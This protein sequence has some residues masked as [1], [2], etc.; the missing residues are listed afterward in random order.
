MRCRTKS[1][2]LPGGHLLPGVVLACAAPVAGALPSAGPVG[3]FAIGLLAI[4]CWLFSRQLRLVRRCER[5]R[6]KLVAE[7]ALRASAERALLERH[8]ALVAR[9]ASVQAAR[10]AERRRIG[11]DIHDDL[12]QH[13]LTLHLDIGALHANPQLPAWLQP[14][15]AMIERHLCLTVRSLRGVIDGLRPAALE[16]GLPQAVR[17]QL[18]EFARLSGVRC[19]LD[20]SG[21][22]GSAVPAVE[23]AMFRILQ[24]ALSNVLRH[25]AAS[26]VHVTLAR[27]PE[28]A[29]LT[30][31][32]NGIGLPP[33]RER[34]GQGLAGIADRVAAAGGRLRLDSQPGEG[35]SLCATV[36]VAP[37]D[38]AEADPAAVCG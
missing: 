10:L 26:E 12:G 28:G 16:H 2:Y 31:R 34:R 27:A 11:R 37:P 29:A 9:D 1:S 32:D 25:A 23:T 30:V 14:Q 22:S 13:L 19:H 36:P 17:R 4:L 20:G 8:A 35:T 15:V 3:W 5:L 6:H 38:M 18:D 21:W 24:E 33:A 7:H